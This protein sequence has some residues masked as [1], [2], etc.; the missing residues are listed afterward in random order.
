MEK[1]EKDKRERKEKN[2][3]EA[4]LDMVTADFSER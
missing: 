3:A 2:E 1:G 4:I